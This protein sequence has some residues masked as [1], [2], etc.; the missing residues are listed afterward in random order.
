MRYNDDPTIGS[1]IDCP[2]LTENSDIKESACKLVQLSLI[3]F[4]YVK[5]RGGIKRFHAPY[6]SCSGPVALVI[7]FKSF[8]LTFS[9]RLLHI[10]GGLAYRQLLEVIHMCTSYAFPIV[11]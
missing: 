2:F 11:W 4:T 1:W 7:K 10:V 9:W 8:S 5:I 6:L 3:I